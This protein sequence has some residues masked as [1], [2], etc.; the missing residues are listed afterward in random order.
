MN[1]LTLF[2]LIQLGT[3]SIQANDQR[4]RRV[5]RLVNGCEANP[6]SIP[7]QVGL[8]T[9]FDT[10]YIIDCAGA[11]ISRNFVLT[12]A[13]CTQGVSSM[14]LYFGIHNFDT[15]PYTMM[16]PKYIFEHADYNAETLENDIALI[17]LPHSV[18]LNDKINIIPL[19]FLCAMFDSYTNKIGTISGWG[20]TSDRSQYQP[21]QLRSAITK[22]IDNVECSNYFNFGFDI[23]NTNICTDGKDG[24]GSICHGD[25]GAPLVIDGV[26][27][28]I[29]S[30]IHQ[31]GCDSKTPSVYTR[32]SHYVS[33]I[34]DTIRNASFP[35]N[36]MYI[37]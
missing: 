31:N 34:D 4:S 22:I 32:V 24:F 14:Y 28:G 7:Y 26:L 9:R 3:I 8:R 16:S 12:A 30:F 20:K 5:K 23:R 36:H 33:W 2:F 10:D 1:F 35:V 19:P 29:A 6:L 27:V 17:E 37:H 11:L 15:D 18:P 25:V 13:R 21:K